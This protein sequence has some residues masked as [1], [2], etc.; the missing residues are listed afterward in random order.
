[1]AS[2]RSASTRCMYRLVVAML[3]C[4]NS[5]DVPRRLVDSLQVVQEVGDAG[6]DLRQDQQRQGR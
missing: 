3:E 1:M 2:M 4:S 6:R 5:V